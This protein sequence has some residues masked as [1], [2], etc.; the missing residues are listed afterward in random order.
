MKTATSRKHLTITSA[1]KE[2]D[3]KMTQILRLIAALAALLYTGAVYSQGTST[4]A[5]NKPN[6]LTGPAGP[7]TNTTISYP[8]TFS[9]TVQGLHHTEKRVYKRKGHD[10][11]TTA[12]YAHYFQSFDVFNAAGNT[13]FEIQKRAVVRDGSFASYVKL[14]DR[15]YGTLQKSY[16][17]FS[18]VVPQSQVYHSDFF[19]RQKDYY[20]QQYPNEGATAVSYTENTSTAAKR[21]VTHYAP[22][23]SNIGKG[24][25]SETIIDHNNGRDRVRRWSYTP[26]NKRLEVLGFYVDKQLLKTTTV[27]ETGAI[28]VVYK[29]RSSGKPILEKQM[30]SVIDG[31]ADTLWSNTYYVYD[32]FHRLI[33]I[34]QPKALEDVSNNSG[35]IVL[36]ADK[37]RELCFEFIYDGQGRL[38]QERKPGETAFTSYVYDLGGNAV[39]VRTPLD[40]GTDTWRV[41]FPDAYGRIVGS[42]TVKTALSRSDLQELFNA[43]TAAPGTLQSY[44]TD[45][46]LIGTLPA[47]GSSFTGG[48]SD[49]YLLTENYYDRYAIPDPSGSY[50]DAIQTALG[51]SYPVPAIPYNND[52]VTV[53]F[54]NGQVTGSRVR[55]LPDDHYSSMETGSWKSSVVRYNRNYSPLYSGTTI[56]DED[57]S[58]L[59]RDYSGTLY[60]YLNRPDYTFHYVWNSRETS[61]HNPGQLEALSYTY[62]YTR[63]FLAE[64]RRQQNGEAFRKLVVYEQ[65]ELGRLKEETLGNLS[66]HRLYTYNLRGQLQGINEQYALTGQYQGTPKTFGEA[67]RYDYGFVQ[68]R[69]DGKISGMIWRGSNRRTEHAYGYSYDRTGRLTKALYQHRKAGATAWTNTDMDFTVSHLTYDLNGN[70]LTM[71]QRGQEASN[72]A[73][74]LID[75]LD[76]TYQPFSNK[77]QGVKDYN[78]IV[79]SM[80]IGDFRDGNG[81]DNDYSYDAAGNLLHDE[82]K[83]IEQISYH[84]V[85]NKPSEIRYSNGA[86]FRYI[87]D[88]G[89]NKLHEYTGYFKLGDFAEKKRTYISNFV[90]L[91]D[92]LAHISHP[93]GRTVMKGVH[94]EYKEEFF[95]KDHLGNVRT[96]I[97]FEHK[98]L[99][100]KEYLATYEVSSVQSERLLFNNIDGPRDISPDWDPTNEFVARLN[101]A[102]G[103]AV[104]TS[105][106]LKVMAGD[107]F[108]VSTQT[109]IDADS[110]QPQPIVSDND[111]LEGLF[112]ALKDN[113]DPEAGESGYH[114]ILE[115]IFSNAAV[116]EG[117]SLLM[118]DSYDSLLPRS[119]LT[120]MLLDDNF[121]PVAGATGSIQAQGGN[122]VWNLIGTGADIDIESNGYLLVLTSNASAKH[123]YF[124]NLYLAVKRGNLL[125]ETH[126]YPHGL[127]IKA[128]ASSDAGHQENRHRYQGNEYIEDNE[129]RWMDFHARQYDPQLGRFLSIDPLAYSGG[130]Q[131]FSPYAAMGNSPGM[132][133]DPN[134][135]MTKYAEPVQDG[136]YAV[137]GGMDAVAAREFMDNELVVNGNSMFGMN[138][139]QTM[140]M[141]AGGG[142]ILMTLTKGAALL[143]NLA[144]AS[145]KSNNGAWKVTNK[146]DYK[147]IKGYENFLKSYVEQ[148]ERSGT[149]FTCED[150]NFSA[151]IAYAATNGLPLQLKIQGKIYDAQSSEFSS[152]EGYRE[153][154]F[155]KSTAADL[156]DPYNTVK[157]EKQSMTAARNGDIVLIQNEAGNRISHAQM[158]YENYSSDMLYIKQGNVSGY[159]Y[160]F[161][162]FRFGKMRGQIIENGSYNLGNGTY[163]RHY[164]EGKSTPSFIQNR[165]KGF[166]RWNFS[167]WNK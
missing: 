17:D 29:H 35:P 119:Y 76:Y 9:G 84:P 146:W 148:H 161:G 165:V 74:Y 60:D 156:A 117:M 134:G 141:A 11:L 83:D 44:F 62:D 58:E 153:A 95:V 43:E 31:G 107:A 113:V 54:A 19:T 86:Y 56:T 157:L 63:G 93:V 6:G 46:Q 131:V 143:I 166:Y 139:H 81:S 100:P 94:N 91:A 18:D 147:A 110:V 112:N 140:L 16:L 2:E 7:V 32:D 116:T 70:I 72:T 164:G 34:I 47:D 21:S 126:Y 8:P 158:A 85:V 79:P 30:E 25:G 55:I 105:L 104:G 90:Y 125:E 64:I 41:S 96:V 152:L 145:D 97:D 27:S 151:V 26:S 130:Q 160:D 88:A 53:T 10:T 109:W 82:N 150:L 120:Y 80:P 14:H 66:E 39:L 38:Q 155:A 106:L 22:G 101:A 154:V 144:N 71:R 50:T 61:I 115:G 99:V 167:N 98:L 87:Y 67:L 23:M 36:S 127:P 133:I 3:H 129:L 75:W 77:L 121:Q 163:Y 89:G 92:G 142:G 138:S 40:A 135:E 24:E 49:F 118:Q 37:I 5:D 12:E 123:V 128:L 20:Q 122:G 57:G 137:H 111:L 124:D 73:P 132:M 65:D 42:G 52:T 68:P 45:E 59:Y 103:T 33:F 69:N 114:T 162:Y 108:N 136:D 28:S 149:M 51:M 1:D 159:E 13:V 102:E 15:S 4:P 48:I 78:T